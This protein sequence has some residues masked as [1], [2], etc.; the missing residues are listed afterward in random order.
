MILFIFLTQI[1]GYMW[2][3]TKDIS[4]P[5]CKPYAI[6]CK[7]YWNNTC[8]YGHAYKKDLK[9]GQ[10]LFCEYGD[11]C[12]YKGKGCTRKHNFDKIINI[13][14]INKIKCPFEAGQGECDHRWTKLCPYFHNG[15]IGNNGKNKWQSGKSAYNK[16]PHQIEGDANNNI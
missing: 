7:E 5:G 2:Y 3:S 13:S 6:V 16:Y 1:K 9:N 15:K 14:N 11:R 4:C 10:N 8:N 12:K